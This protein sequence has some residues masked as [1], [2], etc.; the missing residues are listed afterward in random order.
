MNARRSFRF[1]LLLAMLGFSISSHAQ[2]PAVPTIPDNLSAE[3]KNFLEARR[4]Q[5]AASRSAFIAKVTAHN[6]H[7]HEVPLETPLAQDCAA[8]R[9]RLTRELATLQM[10]ADALAAEIGGAAGR[11]A[12]EN[13]RQIQRMVAALPKIDEIEKSPAADMAHKALEAAAKHD[14]PVALAWWQTALQRDPAN[15]SLKRSVELA[16]WMANYPKP[17]VKP[18]NPLFKETI[19]AAIQGDTAHA[20]QFAKTTVTEN[21]FVAEEGERIA[22]GIMMESTLRAGNGAPPKAP[23]PG[24]RAVSDEM[25]EYALEA[26]LVGRPN[27]E[28]LFKQADFFYMFDQ[29]KSFQ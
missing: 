16:Q 15:A 6:D 10:A 5:F 11:H 18:A 12:L 29:G 19:S 14:W 21:Q 9:E 28:E 8:A 4:D 26:Q 2:I 25:Y 24:L 13:E 20:I 23:V 7:C 1:V 27:A 17:A 22:S 3:M